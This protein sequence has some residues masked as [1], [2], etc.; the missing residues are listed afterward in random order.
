[1]VCF[2]TQFLAEMLNG[3]ESCTGLIYLDVDS[4]RWLKSFNPN[5]H[6]NLNVPNCNEENVPIIL[7]I[8]AQRLHWTIAYCKYLPSLT[9]SFQEN[10]SQFRG[11]FYGLYL[12]LICRNV[13]VSGN[14]FQIVYFHQGH[15]HCKK[16]GKLSLYFLLIE[17]IMAIWFSESC[18]L[19]Y[20]ISY[21]PNQWRI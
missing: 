4:C 17:K 21:I 11:I 2:F 5:L 12:H 6:A 20:A 9:M 1:M 3:I 15:L 18:L 8:N 10:I 16:W 19:Y 7:Q 14:I 13:N